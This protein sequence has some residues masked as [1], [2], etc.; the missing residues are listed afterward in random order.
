MRSDPYRNLVEI[1]EGSLS[2]VDY[3]ARRMIDVP[4][5]LQPAKA[6]MDKAI[7]DLRAR[8][9]PDPGDPH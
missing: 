2:L 4:D 1:L 9:E 8:M 3:Y 5:S 7:A 6:A